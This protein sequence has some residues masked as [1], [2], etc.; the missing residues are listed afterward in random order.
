MMASHE[1]FCMLL[2]IYT[3]TV[4]GKDFSKLLINIPL[5]STLAFRSDDDYINLKSIKVDGKVVSFGTS[6]LSTGSEGVGGA[7]ISTLTPYTV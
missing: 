4:V 5:I 2:I 3:Y 1:Y 6:L 7:K